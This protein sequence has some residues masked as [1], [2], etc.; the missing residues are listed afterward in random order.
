MNDFY[1]PTSF[2]TLMNWVDQSASELVSTRQV[3]FVTCSSG[4]I[5]RW[6]R[7]SIAKTDSGT[8]LIKN[9]LRY[10]SGNPVYKVY[11]NALESR[12]G[13]VIFRTLDRQR[14]GHYIFDHEVNSVPWLTTSSL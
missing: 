1:D 4:Y 7:Q 10:P 8:L 12:S 13:H 2:D 14:P 3:A 9:A 11:F 5:S 6:E